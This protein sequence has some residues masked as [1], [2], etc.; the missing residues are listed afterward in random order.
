VV[1]LLLL[2]IVPVDECQCSDPRVDEHVFGG[3]EG[4]PVQVTSDRAEDADANCTET[5]V[6]PEHFARMESLSSTQELPSFLSVT[7][8]Q[9]SSEDNGVANQKEN[10]AVVV[11]E[12]EHSSGMFE[13]TGSHQSVITL[14]E[15]E[16]HFYVSDSD[17]EGH[18][19]AQQYRDDIDHASVVTHDSNKSSVSTE[20]GLEDDEDNVNRLISDV[21][22]L[23]QNRIIAINNSYAKRADLRDDSRT[24]RHTQAMN[25]S[26][27]GPPLPNRQQSDSDVDEYINNV[28]QQH[29]DSDVDEYINNV[30]Q[31]EETFEKVFNI[32]VDDAFESEAKHNFGYQA[33]SDGHA[34]QVPESDMGVSGSNTERT[35]G[36]NEDNLPALDN[37]FEVHHYSRSSDTGDRRGAENDTTLAERVEQL[38]L[39]RLPAVRNYTH[40]D[41]MVSGDTKR[42]DVPLGLEISPDEIDENGGGETHSGVSLAFVFDSTG[43]MWD[44][45]VQVKIGAERIMATMLERPDKPIYNYVLVPFHDPSK[46]LKYR[47]K[48]LTQP[49]NVH[50]SLY[51]PPSLSFTILRS[52]H[53][54]YLC[55]LCGSENKQPLFPYTTLTD[56]F[57]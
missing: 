40:T 28:F 41:D 10:S 33:D 49:F 51:V 53:T 29:S 57:V 30:F 27:T 21:S 17:T 42:D 7:N 19:T 9:K 54:L 38:I 23:Y 47:I 43:S 11:T 8:L 44:D 6:V 56:W 1:L 32:S 34:E 24:E 25:E 46:S 15:S 13:Q 55:F 2:A 37:V 26:L 5:S 31:G 14:Q 22:T 50:W 12:P 45:L 18:V 52:A 16:S 39:N 20:G 35:S 48:R 4:A 3:R 36:D